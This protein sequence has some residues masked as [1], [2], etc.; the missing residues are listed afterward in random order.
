MAFIM[1]YIMIFNIVLLFILYEILILKIN[2]F[3]IRPIL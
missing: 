1:N 3:Y 2:I